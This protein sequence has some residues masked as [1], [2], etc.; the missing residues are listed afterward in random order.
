MREEIFGGRGRMEMEDGGFDEILDGVMGVAGGMV[1][2]EMKFC[3]KTTL[4]TCRMMEKIANYS[5]TRPTFIYYLN[6]PA[7]CKILLYSYILK[8]R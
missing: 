8:V 5:K 7:F 4:Q 6:H 1:E 3:Q 2:E